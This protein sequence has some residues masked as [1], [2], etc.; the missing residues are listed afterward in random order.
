MTGDEQRLHQ[1]VTNLLSNARKP[2]PAGHDRHGLG[3]RGHG[4][5]CHRPRRRPR[6]SRR[7][8]SHHAF[9]RFTRG[10]VART[11]A[12]RRRRGLGL[13]L[14]AA[15]VTAHGGTVALRSEPGDTTVSVELPPATAG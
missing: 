2:H 13:S 15:I 9:E 5:R 14:V 12:V 3:D 11:R 6:A 8:S 10:D 1:V 4:R 7:I